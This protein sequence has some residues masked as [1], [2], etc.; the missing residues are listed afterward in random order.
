MKKLMKKAL[1]TLSMVTLIL[2]LLVP[3]SASASSDTLGT[4]RPKLY[5]SFTDANGEVADGNA[6]E[7][8][9]YNVSINLYGMT[10][11]SVFEL[12][13]NTTD[14]ITINSVST[15][16]DTDTSFDC[17][18]IKNE[19]NNF[20]VIFAS[21]NDD[22][23]AVTDGQSMITLNVTVNTAGDFA[24]YFVV[25]TD[26]DTTFVEA[27]YTDGFE[28]A[29]VCSV[30]P[31]T[32]TNYPTLTY[33]MSPNLSATTFDVTGQVGIATNLEGTTNNGGIIGLTVSVDGTD[34]SAVSDKDGYYTLS[35]LEEGT[36]TLT[37]TGDT[38]IAR[39]VTLVVSADKAENGT[40]T[41]GMVPICVCDYNP[42]GG[43]NGADTAI[44]GSSFSEYNVYADLNPDG[45]IN[46]ADTA[47]YG[48]FFGNT[49][50]YSEV[51]L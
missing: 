4:L 40:I 22:Y 42:D 27:D 18:N 17:A 34:I 10:T 35:G 13:A 49:V 23:S 11:L 14:D 31:A 26:P 39:H 36:Y 19:D 46:G 41:V 12:T 43:I 16:A 15:V 21:D 7:V 24:D 30:N 9:E 25:S 28:A 45:G 38:A 6:L 1:A 20:V 8:G 37:I 33:D 3:F 47:I 29:Y 44:F 32:D 51:T 50:E 5:A 48:I 2:T